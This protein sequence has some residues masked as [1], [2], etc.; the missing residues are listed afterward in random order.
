MSHTAKS[1]RIVTTRGLFRAAV[2]GCAA[3]AAV[4]ALAVPA[5]AHITVTPDSAPA[6]SA[7]VLTFHVPN[8]EAT[9]DTVKVDVKIPTNHPIVD[10]LVEPVPGWTASV[11]K[12]NLAK[13]VTTDDGKFTQVVSEVIWTGGKIVPGQFQDFSVSCDPLPTGVSSIAFKA[14]QT[15]ANGD[16]VRW[17]DLAAP[18]QA[19]PAHPAPILA[20]T[21][22]TT[23]STQSA[24]SSGSS[25]KS[26]SSG[27]AAVSDS[28]TSAGSNSSGTALVLAIAAL[29]AGLLALAAAGA[30]LWRRRTVS[31][32]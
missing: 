17:I 2:T 19:E 1:R 3:S 24:G 7:A 8:E 15:Y 21:G 10:L 28:S 31:G 29:V 16:V 23:S 26:S 5:L 25:G 14:L 32:G 11:K 12:I 18:G 9:A 20:L 4:L 13:P 30:G 22:A 6:G 27:T